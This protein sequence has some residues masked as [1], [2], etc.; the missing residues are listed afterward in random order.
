MTV[1]NELK[2][3]KS[4]DDAYERRGKVN[5]VQLVS[6]LIKSITPSLGTTENATGRDSESEPESDRGAG[7]SE[8]YTSAR[9]VS[10]SVY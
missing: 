7:D 5:G 2:A 4:S 10:K 9:R 3:F 6:A 1:W 8:N